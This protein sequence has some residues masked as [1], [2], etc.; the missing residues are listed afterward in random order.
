LSDLEDRLPIERSEGDLRPPAADSAE[1]D[2]KLLAWVAG[3]AA[4]SPED[5]EAKHAKVDA[6]G[7]EIADHIREELA[8]R[9][10]ETSRPEYAEG[11]SIPPPP[12]PPQPA[13]EPSQPPVQSTRP[14]NPGAQ[15]VTAEEQREYES[16]RHYGDLP[17]LRAGPAKSS[18]SSV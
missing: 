4:L 13:P 3:I 5:V 10:N 16:Q 7:W 9:A 8:R 14:S 11:L 2:S 12:D 17:A 18:T 6:R 15:V 1:T